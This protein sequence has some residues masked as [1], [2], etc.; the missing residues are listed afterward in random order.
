MPL[1]VAT[2]IALG[3]GNDTSMVDTNSDLVI[4]S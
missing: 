2:I 3:L 1:K 4:V